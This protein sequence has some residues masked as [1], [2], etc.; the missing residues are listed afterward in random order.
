MINAKDY[1]NWLHP[2]DPPEVEEIE[3]AGF[4]AMEAAFILDECA[5][6]ARLKQS[7]RNH[8]SNHNNNG[9]F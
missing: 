4:N 5:R 9:K 8:G 2:D 1:D 7:E 6:K 3:E